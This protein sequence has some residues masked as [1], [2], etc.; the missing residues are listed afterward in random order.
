MIDQM[1]HRFRKD[2]F[3]CIFAALWRHHNSGGIGDFFTVKLLQ[4]MPL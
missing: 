3:C 2:L 4:N 1:K